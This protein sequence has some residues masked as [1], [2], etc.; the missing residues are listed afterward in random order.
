MGK[1]AQSYLYTF[2][3]KDEKN[4]VRSCK[5]FAKNIQRTAKLNFRCWTVPLDQ[6]DVW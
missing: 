6:L 1:I 2:F 4:P 5:H 3:R